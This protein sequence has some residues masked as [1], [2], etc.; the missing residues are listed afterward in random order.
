[1]WSVADS[2]VATTASR[3]R[4][5]SPPNRAVLCNW[6]DTVGAMSARIS[7]SSCA[8]I[9]I[10]QAG[11]VRPFPPSSSAPQF[12]LIEHADRSL[13]GVIGIEVAIHPVAILICRT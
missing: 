1:M 4:D 7:S 12:S 5:S 11:A 9:E 13:A 8:I 6:S 2:R 3:D 10:A